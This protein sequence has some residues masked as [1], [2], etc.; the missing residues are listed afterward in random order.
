MNF[1][2]VKIMENDMGI[3][4][5]D[6]GYM[7][8]LDQDRVNHIYGVARH[9]YH[10]AMV[11][12]GLE[13]LAQELFAL[14]MLHDIGY[15]FAEPKDHARVGSWIMARTGFDCCGEIRKHGIYI[16]PDGERTQS[17]SLITLDLADF[18]TSS[19]GNIVTAQERID[20]MVVRYGEG[21][22]P[23][24]LSQFMY[25][26]YEKW[27]GDPNFFIQLKEQ[28]EKCETTFSYPPLGSNQDE[29]PLYDLQGLCDIAGVKYVECDCSSGELIFLGQRNAFRFV[30]GNKPS[31]RIDKELSFENKKKVVEECLDFILR[32]P[33]DHPMLAPGDDVCYTVSHLA[34]VEGVDINELVKT[35]ELEFTSYP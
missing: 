29:N 21:S 13:E 5:R 4:G 3:F 2:G 23:H 34:C 8:K 16:S 24:R 6:L 12:W 33:L 35:T 19:D 26:K 11:M 28:I 25:K 15:A 1:V 20:G 30:F 7:Y 10:I 32:V 22:I 31:I 14:G 17:K 27:L 9:C 18:L